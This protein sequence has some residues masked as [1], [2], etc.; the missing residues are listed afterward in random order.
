MCGRLIVARLVISLMHAKVEMLTS[1]VQKDM[2]VVQVVRLL[3]IARVLIKP[4]H[5]VG[6][7][8][9]SKV[10]NYLQVMMH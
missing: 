3:I 7:L 8:K 2:E 4:N 5:N 6:L 1:S 9:I 10:S